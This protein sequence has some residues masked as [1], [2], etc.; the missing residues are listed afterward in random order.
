MPESHIP[1]G[2]NRLKKQAELLRQL[3]RKSWDESNQSELASWKQFVYLLIIVGALISVVILLVSEHNRRQ[4]IV[5]LGEGWIQLA[6]PQQQKIFRLPPPP[7]KRPEPKV[8]RPTFTAAGSET[9][10]D[11]PQA[12]FADPEV[13]ARKGVGKRGRETFG[14]LT[15]VAPPKTSMNEQAY[16]VLREESDLVSRLVGGSLSEL[17]F[18]TWK[19]LKDRPPEFWID[20]TAIRRADG[21]QIHLI[22][23]VN[24]ESN[25]IT[26]LSQEARDLEGTLQQ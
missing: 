15:P 10:G 17:E 6:G 24:L 20:L 16:G 2:A 3:S 14:I 26:A 18:K 22:W 7:P 25:E 1:Q 23:S 9:S 5:S 12:I 11:P 19:P 13:T 4:L 8:S 21:Q